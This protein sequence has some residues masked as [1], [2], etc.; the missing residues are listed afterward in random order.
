MLCLAG[1]FAYSFNAIGM[2]LIEMNMNS[3]QLKAQIR[4]LNHYLKL[5]GVNNFLQ[6]KARRFIEYSFFFV[7]YLV[8]QSAPRVDQR[9][10]KRRTHDQ[11]PLPRTE[12]RN[13]PGCLL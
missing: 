12:K 4:D 7:F 1:T 3:N 11:H 10:P 5:R 13:L 6:D 2:I 8:K 9:I